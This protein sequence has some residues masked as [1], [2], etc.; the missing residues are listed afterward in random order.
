MG[1]PG[2]K[3]LDWLQGTPVAEGHATTRS[4]S[5]GQHS[6]AQHSTARYLVA[7]ALCMC[8]RH[9]A[10][11]GSTDPSTK[12]ILRRIACCW[13]HESAVHIVSHT[14]VTEVL[15]P[16][17][18]WPPPSLFLPAQAHSCY[19]KAA[20]VAG[21]QH[22]QPLHPLPP[23]DPYVSCQTFPATPHAVSV[24]RPQHPVRRPTH[25]L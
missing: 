11:M 13:C 2:E 19:T 17:T 10:G 6:T 7:S 5:S 18:L 1:L 16:P 14:K 23:L 21:V 12:G 15:L 8:V 9:T 24:V 22:V 25:A 3:I 4:S 20:M